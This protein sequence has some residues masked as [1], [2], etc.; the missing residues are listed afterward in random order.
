MAITEPILGRYVNLRS[1]T[2]EDAEFT[3][4]IRRDPRFVRFLP[5]IDNTV[6]QQRDWIRGQREKQGDYFFVVWDKADNRIGTISIY[7][8]NGV[9]G[10]SG[11]L[12]IRGD[13]AFQGIEA[14][15]LS[16]RFAFDVLGL[17]CIDA[18][19]YADNEQGIR[20]NRQFGGR[21]FPPEVDESGREIIR[22]QNWREDFE[23]AD[24]RL[25]SII[26]R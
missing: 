19:I 15:I 25:S 12:A 5:K 26:Y 1:S 10:E 21:Q 20:F 8:V 4:D 2:V 9:H 7:G 14:Q 24:K 16:F 22:C 13:N 3:R 11:R 6:E 18:F 17:E 23:K